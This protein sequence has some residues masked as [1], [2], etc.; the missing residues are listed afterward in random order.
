MGGMGGMGV[1]G[2]S[3]VWSGRA[4]LP[5]PRRTVWR[6]LEPWQE[7]WWGLTGGEQLETF[8]GTSQKAKEEGRGIFW[9][10]P[11][12]SFLIFHTCLPLAKAIQS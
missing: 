5:E 8:P 2:Y 11:A 7:P 6:G 10:P 4:V 1:E 9:F 12:S 3:G